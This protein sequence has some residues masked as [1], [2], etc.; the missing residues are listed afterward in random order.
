M[1]TLNDAVDA[2]MA[3][4]SNIFPPL[5]RSDCERLILAAIA[6]NRD[7]RSLMG[8]GSGM[9]ES[10]LIERL[11]DANIALT[12]SDRHSLIRM[13]ER[14]LSATASNLHAVVVPR[15]AAP[16]A[17]AQN[18]WL[19][20]DKCAQVGGHRFGVGVRWS[21]VI[22]A[23]QRHFE[24]MTDPVEHS[25]RIRRAELMAAFVQGRGPDTILQPVAKAIPR[26]VWETLQRVRAGV[27]AAVLRCCIPDADLGD[28]I[29]ALLATYSIGVEPGQ[30]DKA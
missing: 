7:T 25:A 21:D 10:T 29:D 14:M 1:K 17:D 3:E 28:E 23:A 30:N 6:A 18:N 13:I 27:P 5:R 2:A 12:P 26:E 19:R 16:V 11:R 8:S 24:Y 4:M 22:G 15:A 9:K 20:L